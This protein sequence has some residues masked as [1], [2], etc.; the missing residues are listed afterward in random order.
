MTG[1]TND[2]K[3]ENLVQSFLLA[4]SELYREG[5]THIKN[6]NELWLKI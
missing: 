2:R 5:K 1:Y 6:I 3:G 4:S